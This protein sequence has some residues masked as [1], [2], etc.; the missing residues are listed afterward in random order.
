MPYLLPFKPTYT[1]KDTT[2]DVRF[3][4]ENW[5]KI[6]TSRP[7][8]AKRNFKVNQIVQLTLHPCR[9]CPHTK[10]HLAR[11]THDTTIMPIENFDEQDIVREGLIDIS[12]YKE[13]GQIEPILTVKEFAK[14]FNEMYD[15]RKN[16][17]IEDVKVHRWNKLKQKTLF[18]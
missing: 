5:L 10:L 11:I 14:F 4:L 6:Q 17:V 8:S 9:T 2:L 1:I 13:S 3:L 18:D 7:L 12:L 15:T 16:R